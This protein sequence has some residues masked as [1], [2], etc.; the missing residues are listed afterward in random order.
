M[1]ILKPS[2]FDSK[3]LLLDAVRT[4]FGGTVRTHHA[5]KDNNIRGLCD[6]LIREFRS[7]VPETVRT[8]YIAEHL[9]YQ[10]LPN[11]ENYWYLGEEVKL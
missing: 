4:K 9:G 8:G 5:T 2:N 6:C 10:S 1:I 7:R 3:K 11:I